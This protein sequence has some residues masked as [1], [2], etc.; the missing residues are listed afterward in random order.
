MSIS[1]F[2]SSFRL[3]I[4]QSI[5]CL[6]WWKWTSIQFRRRFRQKGKFC[7]RVPDRLHPRDVSDRQPRSPLTL[8]HLQSDRWPGLSVFTGGSQSYG[9]FTSVEENSPFCL[10]R[11]LSGHQYSY[12]CPTMSCTQQK[13]DYWNQCLHDGILECSG[14]IYIYIYMNIDKPTH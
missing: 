5:F 10:N 9:V 4:N 7:R 8:S 2:I 12:K 11:P 1:T 13:K 3:E 6:L 14:I